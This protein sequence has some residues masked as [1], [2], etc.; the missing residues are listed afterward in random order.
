[1]VNL[2]QCALSAFPVAKDRLRSCTSAL[3][4]FFLSRWRCSRTSFAAC[5]LVSFVCFLT[6]SCELCFWPQDLNGSTEDD[7]YKVRLSGYNDS[8]SLEKRLRGFK[9][10]IVRDYI[11]VNHSI[12]TDCL[13]DYGNHRIPC[14]QRGCE[15][16]NLELVNQ[17]NLFLIGES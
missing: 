2:S 7:V 8:T 3:G 12:Y 13:P 6:A 17:Q 11:S 4:R 9:N 14:R 5:S 1:M 15:V 16:Q 10:V